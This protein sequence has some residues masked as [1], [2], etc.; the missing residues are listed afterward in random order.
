MRYN[1]AMPMAPLIPPQM[2]GNAR[3]SG[4]A[5]RAPKVPRD[6]LTLRIDKSVPAAMVDHVV[7]DVYNAL[8]AVDWADQKGEP[9][10]RKLWSNGPYGERSAAMETYFGPFSTRAYKQLH[11]ELRGIYAL[12]TGRQ[13]LTITAGPETVFDTSKRHVTIHSSADTAQITGMLAAAIGLRNAADVATWIDRRA[14][15]G[16]NC[17]VSDAQL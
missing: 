2:T 14:I 15:A 17:I 12:F 10:Q 16:A 1:L 6:K 4:C 5:V 11:S 8:M 3:R 7:E 9:A 13:P